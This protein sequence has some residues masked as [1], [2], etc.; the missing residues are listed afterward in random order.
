[1]AAIFLTDQDEMS[2]LYEAHSIDASYHVSVHLAK[3]FRRRSKCE[4]LTDDG[5]QMMTKAHMAFR[6]CL[7]WFP[8]QQQNHKFGIYL[9]LYHLRKNKL[10]CVKWFLWSQ[11]SRISYRHQILKVERY[12][13]NMSNGFLGSCIYFS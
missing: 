8:N 13:F 7:Y 10:K 12:I 11:F 9:P 3:R 6:F 4:K 1:M 5:H 2:N